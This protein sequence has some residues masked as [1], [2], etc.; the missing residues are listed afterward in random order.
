MYRVYAV[1]CACLLNPPFRK[2][3][4]LIEHAGSWDEMIKMFIS[5][6]SFFKCNI[7]SPDSS[8]KKK[9]KELWLWLLKLVAKLKSTELT[10][11]VRFLII[12]SFRFMTGRSMIF[13]NHRHRLWWNNGE[14]IPSILFLWTLM[15]SQ[16]GRPQNMKDISQQV[17]F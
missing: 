16:S 11:S 5:T 8:R 7:P 14:P 4:K 3:L 12:H 1:S 2:E 13:S 6:K 17:N 10:A 9:K 15:C